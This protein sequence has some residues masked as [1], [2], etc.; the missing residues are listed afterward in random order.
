MIL[1]HNKIHAIK[2]RHKFC[3]HRISNFNML[4]T[5]FKSRYKVIC[6]ILYNYLE[7][8]HLTKMKVNKKNY[9]QVTDDM[10]ILFCSTCMCGID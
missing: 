9:F 4:L 1:T 6:R 8:N 5:C 2:D 7:V 10:Y 3:I